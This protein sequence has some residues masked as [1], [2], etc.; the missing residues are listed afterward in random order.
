MT[1]TLQQLRIFYSV[2]EGLSFSNAARELYLS[3]P[4]VSTQVKKLEVHFRVEF[5]RRSSRGVELTPAGVALFERVR[6]VLND[7]HELEDAMKEFQRVR[8]M[9]LNIGSTE[10]AGHYVLPGLLAAFQVRHPGIQLTMQ[11]GN[12]DTV[13]DWLLQDQVEIAISARNPRDEELITELFYRD[14]LIVICAPSA[15]F[16][17]PLTITELAVLPK[18]IREQGSA[19]R[20]YLEELLAGAPKQSLV[21][22]ELHGNWAV[23]EAISRG[24]GLGLVPA[25]SAVPW[26]HS[27]KV[28]PLTLTGHEL[29]MPFYVVRKRRRHPSPVARAFLNALS[30][31]D[32]VH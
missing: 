25:R 16:P 28:R 6:R 22:A 2:A 24:M 7:M 20:S 19:S 23:N 17:D 11:L 21:A 29:S 13:I 30:E 26:M 3:Q 9:V 10:T 32:L 27:G 14:E 8:R 18:V 1:F 31:Y 5:F 12:S 4:H 15:N